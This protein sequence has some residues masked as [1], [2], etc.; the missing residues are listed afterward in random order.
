M[1]TPV[2]SGTITPSAETFMLLPRTSTISSPGTDP[3]DLAQPGSV[4]VRHPLPARVR[5]HDQQRDRRGHRAPVEAAQAACSFALWDYTAP[6][7]RSAPR[8]TGT[9]STSTS[10][11]SSATFTGVTYSQLATLR[12]RVF[13]NALSGSSYVESVDGVSLVVNYTPNPTRP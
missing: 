6:P 9:A 2:G 12:V 4:R 5:R 10:N 3:G 1:N 8:Q 7:R 11:V 13:G